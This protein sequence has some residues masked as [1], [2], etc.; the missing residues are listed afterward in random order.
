[1]ALLLFS[2]PSY[3]QGNLGAITG[4]VQDKSGAVLPDAAITITNVD[5]SV[6]WTAKTSTAGY[7]RVPLPPGNYRLQAEKAGFKTGRTEL[8]VVPVEQVVTMDLKLQVGSVTETVEVTSAAPLLQTST[9]EVGS[10]VTPEEFETLP[11]Q[12][13]DG[14]RDLQT[15]IFTSLPGTIGTGGDPTNG[16]W[17]GSING[18]Q[19]FSHE[20]LI[21]GVTIGRFDMS[22]GSLTEFSPGTDAIGEF[23]VQSANYSAEYGETGGGVANFSYKSGTNEFHGSV[24]EYNKNP[25]F[26][27]AGA[28]ADAL[29][30]P[31]DNT[32][33]NDFGA[34]F[35]GPIWKQH[36]FFFFTYEGDRFRD[37]SY[38]GTATIPTAAMLKGDFS[39]MLGP[40][41]Q[42]C[43]ANGTSPCVDALNRP[44][45]QYEIY[46]PTTTRMVGPV[47]NQVP[48]RDPFNY[49][50]KLNVIPPGMFSTAS[51]TLLPLFPNP[52]L[53]GYIRNTPKFGGCCPILDR[54]SYTVKIDHVVTGKQKIWGSF[55]YNWRHRFHGCCDYFPPFPGFRSVP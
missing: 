14:G 18:G 37:F 45:Y 51:A 49:G 28:V 16:P 48:V 44:V 4:T 35:G 30:Q 7:Y 10:S 34:T 13:S 19:L 22:G 55:N 8:I 6:K 27:A 53:S 32:R 24:F 54:D 43:G 39:G 33:D 20:I 11:V 3:A 17:S 1:M 38:S 41:V 47:G 36:T 21:D 25:V 2:I 9:A 15:F 46:D 31:K 52:L 23:K 12:V 50:G 40:Q 42:T 29:N 5:T 26:N